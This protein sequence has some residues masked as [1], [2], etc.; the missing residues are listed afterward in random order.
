MRI[1]L[2]GSRGMLGS[3][4]KR[5]LSDFEFDLLTPTRKDLNLLDAKAV[6]NYIGTNKPEAVIHA[7]ARVGGIQANIE[8]PY[9][10]LTENIRMDS[11]LLSA[12]LKFRV[13]NFLYMA[14][15]CMYP[16]ETLQPMQ[17][18][19]I[20][21]GALEPTNE[22]YALAKLVAT[23]AVE[24]ASTQ[25]GLYWR[26]LILSNLFGPGDHFNSDKSHLLAAIITKVEAAKRTN[27]PE[28]NM[29]GTGN[30]R[31]E[32]TYVEDVAEF[33]VSKIFCFKDL[34]VT[35]NIGLG[36]DYSV[37]EYYQMVA[38]YAGYSGM[39][40]PDASRPEGMRQ[41]LMNIEVAKKLGWNPTTNMTEAIA[42]TYDWYID[43]VRGGNG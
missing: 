29:W 11:N 10:F 16:R 23:K 1:L 33:I 25:Y 42:K 30:V 21:T 9:E 40:N 13:P 18:S 41:K 12:S 35:L 20:L 3:S 26:S 27:A 22:G 38:Q 34:P 39:I 31:R 24:L 7:A 8:S 4:I 19:Q 43:S 36:Q 37:I 17:E 2:T 6:D 5:H 28:I 32:F 14:S 15:S